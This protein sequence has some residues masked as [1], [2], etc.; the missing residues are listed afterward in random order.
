MRRIAPAFFAL[1]LAVS[2][3]LPQNIPPATIPSITPLVRIF[4]GSGT[5]TMLYSDNV[6]CV[7]KATGAATAVTLVASPYVGE[8][9]SIKDCKGDANTNNITITPAAGTI[10]GSA[11]DVISAAYGSVWLLYNGTE[12]SVLSESSG[13]L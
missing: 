8:T 7:K 4:T 3:A 2:D 12:W 10:D 1:L 11:T 6:I 9:V 5:I 13:L